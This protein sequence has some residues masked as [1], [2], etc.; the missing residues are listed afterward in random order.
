VQVPAQP[1]LRPSPL[2]DETVTMVNQQLDLAMD[3]LT[4]LGLRQIRL[5]KSARA[6]ASASIGSDFPRT[7]PARRSGTVS[8]GKT[9]T[10]SSPRPSSCVNAAS[11]LSGSVDAERI[12]TLTSDSAP[13]VAAGRSIHPLAASTGRAALG[14]VTT[15]AREA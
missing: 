6:T 5:G 9:R 11:I 8:F 2:I 10:N 3:I 1:L 13:V 15:D 14:Q 12:T 4:W 7:R